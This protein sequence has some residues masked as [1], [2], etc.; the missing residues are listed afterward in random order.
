MLFE[1]PNEILN[2]INTLENRGFEAFC[3]GG[4]VRDLIMGKKPHD[5]DVTTNA[6]PK[7]VASLFPNTVPTG[8]IHGTI[9]V[10]IDKMP[11]E[12]TTYRSDIGYSDSRRPDS[13]NFLSSV[14]GDLKRRDF[15]VNAICYNP[16]IGIYDPLLGETDIKNKILR[17]VGEP[18]LRFSEDALRIMRTFR[19]SA[20]LDFNIEDN[21]LKEALK[22]SHLLKNISVERIFS[23][24]KKGFLSNHP[25]KLSPIIMCKALNFLGFDA[26]EV[27]SS[28]ALLPQD[29]A[30]RFAKY[31]EMSNADAKKILINLKSDNQTKRDTEKYL[32]MFSMPK[33]SRAD[34]KRVLNLG[35][36]KLSENLITAYDLLNK[37]DYTS[38]LEDILVSREPYCIKMLA[39]D[40]NDLLKQGVLPAN[41]GETLNALLEKV[42]ENPELNSTEVL[43]QIK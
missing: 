16:K 27:P 14:D 7:E 25:E 5:Y 4:S 34:I 43:N 21:T 6:T 32:K 35:G 33:N 40:G 3:V 39:V 24:L 8:I 17:T 13:V 38:V 37:T 9:T 36:L 15:T 26:H 22:L 12:V 10:I 20:T 1:L 11:I 42:I 31:C 23:E 19:F 30:L 28:L 29:F 2:C 18:S 41:I